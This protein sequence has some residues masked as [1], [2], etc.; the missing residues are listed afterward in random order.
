MV[1]CLISCTETY[2]HNIALSFDGETKLMDFGIA[3][4]SDRGRNQT[5]IVK[6]KFP[7]MSPEQTLGKKLDSR[8]DVFSLGIIAR[9]ALTGELCLRDTVLDES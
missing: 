8:S 2:G 9:E 4:A 7:H 3:K 5:G 1:I 6:G